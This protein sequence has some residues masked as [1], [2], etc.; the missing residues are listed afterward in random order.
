[1][2]GD[3]MKINLNIS[4]KV[5]LILLVL[6]VPAFMKTEAVRTGGS[7]SVSISA[8]SSAQYGSTISVTASAS[9]RSH[10]TMYY[11]SIFVEDCYNCLSKSI[12]V[13][14]NHNSD[15]A[16]F[17][18]T[19][20]ATNF[21]G[22]TLYGSASKSVD[23]IPLPPATLQVTSISVNDITKGNDLPITISLKNTGQAGTLSYAVAL[24]M[25]DY[26]DS[27]V[28]IDS[29]SYTFSELGSHS[30]SLNV[31]MV[32]KDKG[33]LSVTYSNG[34]Y[35]T[36]T[37]TFALNVGDCT[38][39]VYAYSSGTYQ[40]ISHKDFK[41]LPNTSQ[42][43]VVY[44][45]MLYDDALKNYWNFWGRDWSNAMEASE[46]T[47]A[48]HDALCLTYDSF[49]GR[50]SQNV[51]T[52]PVVKFKWNIPS[53]A[54]S[55]NGK[56]NLGQTHEEA[57]K[58]VGTQLGLP[59]EW[60]SDSSVSGPDSHNHGFDVIYV[61]SGYKSDQSKSSS[62]E[63]NTVVEFLYTL[64]VANSWLA[65]SW[66]T[67]TLVLLHELLHTYGVQHVLNSVGYI[68]STDIQ[69]W[70]WHSNTVTKLNSELSFYET[71]PS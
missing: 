55:G 61:L 39:Y 43:H 36:S 4:V 63:D 56:Y 32:F 65:K 33:T 5:L 58:F 66:S 64:G 18:A 34:I 60:S 15:P 9:V 62:A 59:Q 70:T 41:V 53:S 44:S 22:S 38:V 47:G 46:S 10:I 40:E 7:I 19:A 35:T 45:V 71:V 24:Q 31:N 37:G 14:L 54:Y 27:W 21:D 25:H 23:I 50:F 3:T 8:P 48:C 1:M 57:R 30:L 13:T 17:R 69:G 51:I 42:K 68:M 52:D 12:T 28:L 20:S 2:S 26:T 16:V 6:S 67:F 11:D 29:G 49:S